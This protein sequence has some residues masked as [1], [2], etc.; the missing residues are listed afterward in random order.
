MGCGVTVV[1]PSRDQFRSLSGLR[2]LPR[3]V[4]QET[5]RTLLAARGRACRRR[6]LAEREGARRDR[7][8]AS[9]PSVVRASM[10]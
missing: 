9:A 1:A 10:A 6:V 3:D 2:R 7:C 4:R 5:W 8:P